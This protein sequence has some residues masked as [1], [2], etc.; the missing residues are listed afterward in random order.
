MIDSDRRRK[1]QT[2]APCSR[3]ATVSA[4]PSKNERFR[5]R[6]QF[7]LSESIRRLDCSD[8]LTPSSSRAGTL[9]RGL[10]DAKFYGN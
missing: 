8:L 10:W 4:T 9:E 2:L 7:T 1:D 5:S 3:A 6:L